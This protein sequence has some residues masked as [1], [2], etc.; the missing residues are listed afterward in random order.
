M[1][2]NNKY[3]NTLLTYYEEEVAGEA[4][5]YGL[6]EHF[7]EQE[8][9]AL[10]AEVENRA[11]ES[12]VSLLNKYQLKPRS[13]TEL[14]TEGKGHVSR[15]ESLTWDELMTHMVVHYPGYLE[16]FAALQKMA[17]PEDLLA[18]N[19]LMNH[20]VAVIE[21]AK[22]ELAGDPDSTAP[23]YKYIQN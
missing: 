17:P 3:L 21:F 22:K 18:L 23:L 9:L 19:R 16:N 5:F 20:E 13:A 15:H 6:M 4:Y 7:E 1:Y 14:N 8:K 11:S 2:P 12:I 10:L